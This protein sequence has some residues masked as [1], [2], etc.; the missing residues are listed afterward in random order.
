MAN[1]KNKQRL[2][3]F[4]RSNGRWA[5]PYLGLTFTNYTWTR[6]PLKAEIREVANY[7][8]KS[9]VRLAPVG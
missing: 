8:L 1:K 3:L 9:R 5:G 6:N 2:G 7:T 4:Y